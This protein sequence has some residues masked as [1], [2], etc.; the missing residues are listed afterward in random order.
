MIRRITAYCIF[1]LGIL[2]ILF[3]RSYEGEMIPYPIVFTILGVFMLIV[4]FIIIRRL[5]ILKN[6]LEY[7]K[8][9][10]EISDLKANGALIKVN[11]N[12]CEIKDHTY[13]ETQEPDNGKGFPEDIMDITSY[14]QGLDARTREKK[15]QEIHQSIVIY[16]SIYNGR[17][18]RFISR[19]IFKDRATLSFLFDNQKETTLYIDKTNPARYYFD[20]DFLD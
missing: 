19:V 5:P 15:M 10:Y 17:P 3:F 1:A 4:G 7:H 13:L 16:K 2:T 8:M 6:K 14:F 20:L 18:R 12:E 9:M 11:L